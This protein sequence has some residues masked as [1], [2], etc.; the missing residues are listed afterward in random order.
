MALSTAVTRPDHG[1][2]HSQQ[3]GSS[4]LP[5]DS[6][7][8]CLNAQF[9]GS[10]L[11]LSIRSWAATSRPSS[12]FSDFPDLPAHHLLLRLSLHRLRIHPHHQKLPLRLRLFA[13]L[14]LRFRQT[15]TISIASTSHPRGL[16][17]PHRLHLLHLLH[18]VIRIA[19]SAA[20]P[21][22][23][24]PRSRLKCRHPPP[25]AEVHNACQFNDNLRRWWSQQQL[26]NAG[27][28]VASTGARI[29]MPLPP[30]PPAS[31]A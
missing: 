24:R 16:P 6:G 27:M 4:C 20:P 8:A 29:L 31:R 11:S 25:P 21:H 10:A 3:Q 19:T 5:L 2:Q 28:V 17:H 1:S 12:R 7:G 30:P 23:P 15:P 26:C 22:L 14:H 13:I 18:R 9:N